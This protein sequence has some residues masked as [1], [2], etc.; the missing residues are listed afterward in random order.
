MKSE[1]TESVNGRMRSQS[2]G[3]WLVVTLVVSNH[4]QAFQVD[5]QVVVIWL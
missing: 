2:V 1:T 4:V 5:N 3:Q